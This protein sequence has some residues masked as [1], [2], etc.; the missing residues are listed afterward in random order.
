MTDANL[1]PAP[2]HIID[3]E[4]GKKTRKFLPI[5]PV[6]DFSTSPSGNSLVMFG[7]SYATKFYAGK[8]WLIPIREYIETK[9]PTVGNF[10]RDEAHMQMVLRSKMKFTHSLLMEK[11]RPSIDHKNMMGEST[12]LLFEGVNWKIKV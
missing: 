4:T 5:W 8:W 2:V 3:P 6:V 11:Y 12:D 10:K 9:A 7:K 1:I